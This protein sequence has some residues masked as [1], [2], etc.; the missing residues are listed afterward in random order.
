MEH[1]GADAGSRADL[2]RFPD[3]HFSVACLCNSSDVFPGELAQR[4]ADIYL[5]SQFKEPGSGPAKP[6]RESLVASPQRLAQYAGRY[7]NKGDESFRF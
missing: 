2:I 6:I 4:V 3:Q 7:W 5:A 1:G